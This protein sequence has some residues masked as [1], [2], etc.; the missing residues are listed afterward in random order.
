MF[1]VLLCSLVLASCTYRV[2][3]VQPTTTTAPDTPIDPKKFIAVVE[4][5]TFVA[6]EIDVMNYSD[7][8]QSLEVIAEVYDTLDRDY[9]SVGT[10][11]VRDLSPG[12][13]QRVTVFFPPGP[14]GRYRNE[15]TIER[16]GSRC[17]AQ[18]RLR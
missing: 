11:I 18:A 3:V 9:R 10:A 2:E 15:S 1:R 4:R 12:G 6:A 7:K 13:A 8:A 16:L 5:C 17:T 14:N